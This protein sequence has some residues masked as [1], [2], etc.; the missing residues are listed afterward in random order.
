MGIK[1]GKWIKTKKRGIEKK[2]K[3]ALLVWGKSSH[4]L[5]LLGNV[6][7]LPA[8]MGEERG[9]WTLPSLLAATVPSMPYCGWVNIIF[10][11]LV[12]AF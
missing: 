10:N 5:N 3:L 2:R 7:Y 8:L 1:T 4:F 6:L 12:T 11:T 9:T